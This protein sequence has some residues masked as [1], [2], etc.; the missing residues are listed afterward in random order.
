MVGKFFQCRYELQCTVAPQRGVC[1]TN[2]QAIL[3]IQVVAVDHAHLHHTYA[4][5]E[6][7]SEAGCSTAVCGKV[8]EGGTFTCDESTLYPTPAEAAQV[9]FH[10]YSFSLLRIC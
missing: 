9:R 6:R 3:P 8:G 7:A 10:C 1:T 5:G 4:T 2:A